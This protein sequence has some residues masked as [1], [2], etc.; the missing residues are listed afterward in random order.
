M[1]DVIAKSDIV[2]IAKR[3]DGEIGNAYTQGPENFELEIL[4]IFKGNGEVEV[5]DFIDVQSWYGIC[6][7]GV[8][9]DRYEKAVVFLTKE[10]GGSWF[11]NPTYKAT[12]YSHALCN[13]EAMTLKGKNLLIWDPAIRKEV[14]YPLTEFKRVFIK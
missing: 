5:G 7:Y 10:S 13:D 14:K 4:E 3:G 12:T 11:S 9:M 1:Q 8:Q 6:P 2:V